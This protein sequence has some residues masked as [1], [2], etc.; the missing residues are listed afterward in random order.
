M[1]EKTNVQAQ[2]TIE[3][4]KVLVDQQFTLLDAIAESVNEWQ[5]R[6]L[7]QTEKLF[8]GTNKVIKETVS[9]AGPTKVLERAVDLVDGIAPKPAAVVRPMVGAIVKLHE[10][11]TK[12]AASIV[13]ETMKV[14]KQSVEATTKMGQTIRRTNLD[15]T[16][17]A[18]D[19]FSNAF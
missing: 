12:Q 16:R 13:D 6:G 14:T 2:Q 3:A 17:A 5:M 1:S 7:E 15:A 18:F 11:N 8:D 10:E 4:W 19:S 9:W